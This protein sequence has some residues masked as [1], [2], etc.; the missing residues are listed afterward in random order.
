MDWRRI[1]SSTCLGGGVWRDI[2]A[3]PS[4]LPWYIV[5][6]QTHV[7][8]TDRMLARAPINKR[9]SCCLVV[10]L[11][12]GEKS[13]G[14]A[15]PVCEARRGGNLLQGG[16]VTL[17]DRSYQRLAHETEAGSTESTAVWGTHAVDHGLRG[18]WPGPDTLGAPGFLA[19]HGRQSAR[20]WACARGTTSGKSPTFDVDYSDPRRR[21]PAPPRD[22][23]PPPPNPPGGIKFGS[24]A[25]RKAKCWF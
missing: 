20:P 14:R 21:G 11:P 5:L 2:F 8:R 6:A 16:Q 15:A 3:A 17:D 1:D 22:Q 9:R 25:F 10:V 23:D 24:T 19:P 18:G 4:Y 12:A 7:F 13:P